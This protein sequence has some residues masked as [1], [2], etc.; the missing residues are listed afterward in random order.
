[1]LGALYAVAP[2]VRL[3]HGDQSKTVDVRIMQYS[4]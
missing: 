4:P 2:S 3:S 1:M